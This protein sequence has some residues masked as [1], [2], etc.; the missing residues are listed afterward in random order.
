MELIATDAHLLHDGGHWLHFW[1]H[2][3]T[4]ITIR[5][6][7]KVV[8]I[9]VDL[10]WRWY[11]LLSDDLVAVENVMHVED[12]CP[13]LAEALVEIHG[14]VLPLSYFTFVS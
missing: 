14:G 3:G 4:F 10:L 13:L 1:Q 7:S 8:G 9:L 11:P 6:C 5:L 2:L 12:T